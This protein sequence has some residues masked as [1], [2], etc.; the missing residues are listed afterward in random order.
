[1]GFLDNLESS[2]KHLEGN[3]ERTGNV[4]EQQRRRDER[5][6]ALAVAP[7]AEALKKS[8]FVND[9]VTHAVRIAHGMRVK[10]NMIWVGSTLRLDARDSTLEL[11]PVPEGVSAVI[12]KAGNSVSSEPV[13]LAGDPEPLA[14]RWLSGLEVQNSSEVG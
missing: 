3:Q 13:D 4:Q 11:Q 2:L 14:Q 12:S 10:V 6:R 8:S 1:M 7:S 5:S 9:L